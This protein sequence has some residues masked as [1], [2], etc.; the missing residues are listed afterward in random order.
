MK[1]L[2]FEP[3]SQRRCDMS[4]AKPV[5]RA[6]FEARSSLP[7]TAACVVANGIR[8]TLTSLIGAP[9]VLRLLEPAIPAPQAWPAIL[10]GVRIYRVRGNVTDAAVVLR[11]SDAAV[12]A[13]ALFGESHDAAVAPHG[14]SPIECDVVDR[15]VKALAASLGAV[16]GTI[17]GHPVECSAY[18]GFVTYFELLIEEPFAAKIGI[19]LAREPSPD[20]RGCL[21][22]RHLAS[23]RLRA[24]ASLDVG[25]IAAAD[26]ARLSVGASLPIDAAGVHRCSLTAHGRRLARGSCGVRNGRYALQTDARQPL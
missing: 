19:A 1:A 15:M 23:V 12:L 11:G 14:L 5:R 6:R 7:I 17:D 8:E 25:V 16:C 26:V 20:A 24:L 21:E 4:A 22:P 9:I 13:A 3:A 10:A 2:G 18:D